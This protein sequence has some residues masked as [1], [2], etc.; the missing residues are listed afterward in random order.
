VAKRITGNAKTPGTQ[1]HD[2]GLDDTKIGVGQEWKLEIE[3]A[4]ARATIAILLVSRNFL[5]SDFIAEQELPPLLQAAEQGGLAVVLLHL[6]HCLYEETDLERY[7]A[8]NNPQQ[9][10]A[11]LSPAKR[12]EIW[13]GVCREIK[14]LAMQNKEMS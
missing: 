3:Q 11:L 10:L 9:P 5:A 14:V 6:G 13:A 1:S 2:R 8:I 7:Q 12:D 4:L